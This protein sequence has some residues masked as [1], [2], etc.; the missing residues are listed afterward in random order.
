MRFTLNSVLNLIEYFIV[1]ELVA[2]IF[3]CKATPTAVPMLRHASYQICGHTD[4]QNPVALICHDVN[5]THICLM[6]EIPGQ[7]RNDSE[8]RGMT[9]LESP[10]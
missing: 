1:Y 10:E 7:A 6:L 4:I 8:G 9:M 3:D 5:V 2:I